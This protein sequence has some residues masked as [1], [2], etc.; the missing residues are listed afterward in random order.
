MFI[1]FLWYFYK[2]VIKGLN[3]GIF[4]LNY[5]KLL[6]IV[7]FKLIYKYKFLCFM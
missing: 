1:K 2:L 7:I 6:L 4:S 3:E 5:W